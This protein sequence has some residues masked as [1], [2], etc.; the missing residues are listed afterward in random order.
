MSGIP[1]LACVRA[2]E[3]RSYQL[4]RLGRELYLQGKQLKAVAED[5]EDSGG[6]GDA[7]LA[8]LLRCANHYLCQGLD[9]RSE[10]NCNRTNELGIRS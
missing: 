4:L 5:I 1:P 7:R 10:G 2:H 8:H 6:R 3:L 9:A